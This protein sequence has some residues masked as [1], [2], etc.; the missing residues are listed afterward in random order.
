[1]NKNALYYQTPYV[2]EFD[3]TVLGCVKSGESFAVTLDQAGFYPEGGG[4]PADHGWIGDATVLDVQEQNN[5]PELV[6]TDRPLESGKIYHCRIDWTRRFRNTQNHSGEHIV[7]GIVHRRFGYH[8]VGFH[9]DTKVAGMDGVMTIDFDGPMTW[10]QLMEIEQEAN[11]VIYED[12]P[13]RILWPS[14]EELSRMDYRSKKTLTGDV[15]LVEIEDADC[16]ACC[17]THVMRTGEIGLIKILS[18]MSHRGGVRLEM[19]AGQDAF[20]DYERKHALITELSRMLSVNAG[21]SADALKKYMEADYRKDQR[22]GELNRKLFQIKADGLREYPERVLCDFEEGMNP[23]ELRKCCDYLMRHTPAEVVGVFGEH[24]D[25]SFL[26]VIG[27]ETV[28]VRP[29]G[30]A[31]NQALQGR[32]GG[33]KEM[34]QGSVQAEQAK[35]E[36]TLKEIFAV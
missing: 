4:Q 25:H 13:V 33:Q 22:I 16:C 10:E 35:I 12:R 31:F 2:K 18:V 23:V 26:Y 34:I 32:G 15:R 11:Q 30:K 27:S 3:A 36:R 28:D 1:M 21:D 17:G 19:V 20:H 6:Y 9:M 8:N 7:S 24:E 14:A 5:G 29:G